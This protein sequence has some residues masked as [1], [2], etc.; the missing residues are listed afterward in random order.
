VFLKPG[1]MPDEVL[2][3]AGTRFVTRN[4]AVYETPNEKTP[5]LKSLKEKHYD[6]FQFNVRSILSGDQFNVPFLAE[7]ALDPSTPIESTKPLEIERI[8]CLGTNKLGRSSLQA[9]PK[10][11]PATSSDA[12]VNA[13][14]DIS[15]LK[16]AP[17]P[18]IADADRVFN[19][20]ALQVQ[21]PIRHGGQRS[22]A[23]APILAY[24]PI[25][26]DAMLPA[27][28]TV[29]EGD[30]ADEIVARTRAGHRKDREVRHKVA[31]LREILQNR[32]SRDPNPLV[33]R[34]ASP[35]NGD[36]PM[37]VAV[38]L[39]NLL[40]MREEVD[41]QFGPTVLRPFGRPYSPLTSMHISLAKYAAET[42]DGSAVGQN[43]HSLIPPGDRRD[44]LWDIDSEVG[45]CALR[46]AADPDHSMNG[47]FG[48]LIAEPPGTRF[49]DG[50][51]NDRDAVLPGVHAMVHDLGLNTV[52]REYVL[53]LQDG[54]D[55]QPGG[56]AINYQSAGTQQ[57]PDTPH[58]MAYAGEEVRVRQIHAAG[59]GNQVGNHSFFIGG[60]RWRID[61]SDPRSNRISAISE[62]PLSAVNIRFIADPD[63]LPHPLPKTSDRLPGRRRTYF[64]GS[65]VADHLEFGEWGEFTVLSDSEDHRNTLV[66]LPRS[67]AART[68]E[69]GE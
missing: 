4:G 8:V 17:Q 64:Y 1:S 65:R 45:I 27:S 44:Y 58:L 20:A 52:F 34:V 19:I 67:N 60:R 68:G 61:D 56:C 18:D 32:F 15:L 54:F 21:L 48:A 41:A 30:L 39:I 42:N 57:N 36:A 13:S 47:L 35:A 43:R 33:I 23:T 50:N 2:V 55:A 37:R 12:S 40:P 29:T 11:V 7:L 22:G 9:L 3:R 26:P 51:G 14:P 16:P 10:T 46:D 59:T 49:L 63:L 66:P 6:Y 28:D 53:F 5:N 31:E 25:Q 62:A 24:V 69:G 38:R